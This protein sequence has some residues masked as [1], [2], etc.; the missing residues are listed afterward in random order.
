MMGRPRSV[1][2]R[3][4]AVLATAMMG[5]TW[6]GCGDGDFVP[7]PPPP[8][9]SR[10]AVGS[11]GRNTANPGS[12]AAADPFAKGA[13]VGRIDFIAS[14]R[15][16]PEQAELEASAAR[17]QAGFERARLHVLPDETVSGSPESS[18]ARN[19]TQAELVRE[20]IAAKPRALI[21]DPDDP[22]DKE[23]A[24]A[25]QEARA[26]RIPVILVGRPLAG[27][28]ESKAPGAAPMI[29]VAPHAFADSARR[30][31]ELAIRNV[32]N[33]KLDPVGG[34]IFLLTTSGDRLA[35][36][37]AAAIKEAL[38][39]ARITA[40]DEVAITKDLEPA[41]VLLRK[42]LEA[43]PKPV[44]VFFFDA[45]GALV[46]SKV[47]GEIGEQRPFIL[48]GYSSDEGRTR[49]VQF[50]EYAAVGEYEPNR[51]IKKAVTVAA[52]AA[53]AQ[54]RGA[55]EREE[56]PITVMESPP[57]SGIPHVQPKKNARLESA[58]MKGE[59]GE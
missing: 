58:I 23:L 45:N 24:R 26:A 44:M 59:K 56:I 17:M 7:P 34:A 41:S 30:I 4:G 33:G 2:V 48:A 32:K 18:S 50:G 31:V 29:L 20:S 5:T 40:V 10:D 53:A 15:A 35:T 47:A 11:A 39:A 55:K 38:K 51:L 8:S 36:D 28:G 42:R 43:N 21:V 27:S 3:L 12:G 1:R 37:R 16:A 22:A 25:I 14:R 46:A 19:R 52:A 49:M 6:V 57:G 54:G 9:E 13:P